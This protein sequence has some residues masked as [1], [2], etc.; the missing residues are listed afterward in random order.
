MS[1][2]STHGPSESFS[3]TSLGQRWSKYWH[4]VAIIALFAVTAGVCV[5]LRL[6]GRS[7]ESVAQAPQSAEE[8]SLAYTPPSLPQAPS[9]RSMLLRLALGTAIVLSL[10][11]GTLW[12]GKRW[13]QTQPP[14]RTDGEIRLIETLPLNRQC[15]LHLVAAAGHQVLVGVD[16]GG[17]KSIL[18]LAAPFDQTLHDLQSLDTSA[19]DR[20]DLTRPPGKKAA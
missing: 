8:G 4:Y 7:T 16:G 12:L 13:L 14:A 5:P 15:R 10:C 20:S 9:A 2:G 19:A 18:S 11:A 3:A 17:I 1:F 6:P